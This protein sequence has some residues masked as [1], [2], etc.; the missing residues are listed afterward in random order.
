MAQ[1]LVRTLCKE[2]RQR[3]NI[4]SDM[5]IPDDFPLSEVSASRQQVYRPEGCRS[6]R[7]TGYRGRMGIYELLFANDKIRQLA[8]DRSPTPL[9]KQAAVESGMQT[10][11]QDGWQKV[12][13]GVTSIDEV[14]RVTKSD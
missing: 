6:C 7:G 1:R 3:H 14:L 5:T 9:V 2:C 4:S 10:L 12:L 11:R 8:N 13:Q